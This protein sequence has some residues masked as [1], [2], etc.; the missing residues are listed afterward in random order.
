MVIDSPGGPDVLRVREVPDPVAEE[1]E[2]LVRV[3]AAGVNRADL[4]QR[5]GHYP[6]PPGASELPGLECSGTVVAHGPGVGPGV[7]AGSVGGGAPP[8]GSPVMALLAGGGYAELVAVP[9]G[10]VLTLPERLDPVE[11]GGFMET[12]CTVWSTVVMLGGLRAGGTLLV[13]GGASGIGTT[14]V[15]LGRALGARVLVTAGT[16]A[17]RQS[18]LDAGA[19]A[20]LDYH[21]EDWPDQVL[22]ATDGAGVDVVLDVVGGPYLGPDL[23]ALATGGRIVVIG[24]QGGPRGELDLGMLLVK[25]AGV[26]A[27]GLRARPVAEKAAVVAGVGEHVLPMVARGAVSPVVDRVLP[28]DRAADAHAAL[29]GGEVVGK[30][31]LTP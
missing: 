17:K 3:T 22:A 15:Q 20:A 11:A 9:A 25:R 13:H 21:D 1:G 8:V 23:R 27:A 29:A 28:F 14:A 7:G 24:L 26:L 4:M 10:Q 2:V 6:P 16:A 30:V 18:C 5:A 19:A 12:T 31:V